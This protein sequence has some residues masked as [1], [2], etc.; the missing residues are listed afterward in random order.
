MWIVELFFFSLLF[1]RAN[2]FMHFFVR[3][4]LPDCR[5]WSIMA[6]YHCHMTTTTKYKE[7]NLTIMGHTRRRIYKKKMCH[8]SC[9]IGHLMSNNANEHR[10]SKSQFIMNKSTNIIHYDHNWKREE[11]NK[12]KQEK[13]PLE[14]AKESSLCIMYLWHTITINLFC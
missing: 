2:K 12:T 7:V 5:R 6:S 11:Q 14:F 3:D 10:V 9:R 4:S 13:I 8:W 1:C